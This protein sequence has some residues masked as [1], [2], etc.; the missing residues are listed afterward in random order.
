MVLFWKIFGSVFSIN[1]IIP[2][3]TL[4][5]KG[6]FKLKKNTRMSSRSL[7]TMELDL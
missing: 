7:T 2:A 1:I 5:A 6:E 3:P 4:S